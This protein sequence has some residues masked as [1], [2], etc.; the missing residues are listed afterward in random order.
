VNPARSH[1]PTADAGAQRAARKV[2]DETF[3][4]IWLALARYDIP[5][6]DRYDLA[7]DILLAALESWPRYDAARGEAAVWLN[8]IIRNHLLRYTE[9]RAKERRRFVP[10]EGDEDAETIETA[11]TARDA[12][13]L[14][15]YD[16]KRRLAHQLYRE[17]PFELL[18]V[19]IDHDLDELTLKEVADR[20][21]I[22]VSTAHDRYNA[23]LRKLRAALKRWEAK[24]RDR[25]VL[26]LPLA[27]ADLLD[28]DRA[29]PDAPDGVRE[30]MWQRFSRAV[31]P[32]NEGDGAQPRGDGPR[33]V[34]ASTP[35]D[36]IQAVQRPG[37]PSR[38]DMKVPASFGPGMVLPVLG[39]LIVGL[40]GGAGIHAAATRP[41][42]PRD[43]AP[44]LVVPMP[45]AASEHEAAPS[46]LV[47]AAPRG[48]RSAAV[49]TSTGRAGPVP[50]DSE[51]LL[52]EEAA[53]D[54]A[55]AAF[56]QGNMAAAI[57]A[58]AIHARDFPR[59][60]HAPERDKMWIDA[61]L[62]SGRKEEACR[63]AEV[64]RRMYPRSAYLSALET[65]CPAR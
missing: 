10:A 33:P 43:D 32:G 51:T 28:A 7:H 6:Q 23:A 57:N 4:R 49:P 31:M 3:S 26:V 22:P 29:V 61:L 39:A 17:I 48:A 50:V 55:R 24:H 8:G 5:H 34:P 30:H 52:R 35:S 27:V 12:L 56:V 36:A 62:G 65:P 46:V 14:L 42:A 37:D 1:P 18:S 53:F 47:S 11:D 9:R 60:Q 54:T 59:G 41:P 20:H 58:L 44:A 25:G 63:R 19:L 15:M 13:E 64:F 16:E 2:F 21:Q 45:P 40:I 38:P